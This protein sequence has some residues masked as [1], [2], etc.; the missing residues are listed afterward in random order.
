MSLKIDRLFY[1]EPIWSPKYPFAEMAVGD[2]FTIPRYMANAA[3]SSA[4][5]F[6]RLQGS[7]GLPTPKFVRRKEAGGLLTRF[8]RTE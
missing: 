6:G 4:F 7:R 2:S 5:Q 3:S 8:W 1:T